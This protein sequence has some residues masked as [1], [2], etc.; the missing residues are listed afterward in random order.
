MA[1][2]CVVHCHT[3]YSPDSSWKIADVITHC[4]KNRIDVIAITDHDTIDGALAVQASAPKNLQVIVGQEISTTEGDLV[5]LFLQTKIEA[6]RSIKDTIFEI[7]RQNGVVILPHPFDRLRHHAVGAAVSE[8]IK[9]DID[10]IETFNAR[11][12]FSADNIRAEKFAQ[13]NSLT[14]IAAADA[15]FASE[16]TNAV[17]MLNSCDSSSDFLQSVKHAQVE[18]H[19]AGIGVHLKTAFVKIAKRNTIK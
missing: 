14:G 4:Q 11:C 13:D 7:R 2:R 9:N 19:L 17:C 6:Q 10:L 3:E 15:H 16:L 8:A 1:L 18:N 5:G 12:V